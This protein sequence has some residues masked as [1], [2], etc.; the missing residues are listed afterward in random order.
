LI[1]TRYY[2]IGKSRIEAQFFNKGDCFPYTE[3][4]V[5]KPGIWGHIAGEDWSVVY[6]L[7]H[8]WRFINL[9]PDVLYL[10]T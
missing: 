4:T 3:M 7:G 6:F 9:N 5:P 2:T 8:S 10:P 1:Q